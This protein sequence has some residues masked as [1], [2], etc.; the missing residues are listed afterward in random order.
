MCNV[1]FAVLLILCNVAIIHLQYRQ[2]SLVLSVVRQNNIPIKESSTKE[3]Q[4]NIVWYN[5]S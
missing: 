5:E 1:Q 2:L 3:L 4:C